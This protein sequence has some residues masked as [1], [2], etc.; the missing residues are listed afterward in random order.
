MQKVTFISAQPYLTLSFRGLSVQFVEHY[1]S[2]EDPKQIQLLR[3]YASNDSVTMA[4]AGEKELEELIKLYNEAEDKMIREAE[5]REIARAEEKER[6]KAIHE[7]S[8]TLRMTDM[9][10]R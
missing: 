1:Y 2:T 6:K 8:S 10:Y 3:E 4:E 5:E 7:L 9:V